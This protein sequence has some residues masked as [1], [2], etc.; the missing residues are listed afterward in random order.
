MIN[1]NIGFFINILNDVSIILSANSNRYT[2]AD[3][4]LYILLFLI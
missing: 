2:C 3:I 1:K 4:N